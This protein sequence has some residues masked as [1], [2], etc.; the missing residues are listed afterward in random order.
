MN[1]TEIHTQERH[2]T[3]IYVIF[4]QIF[5]S[6]LWSY[7]IAKGG[8]VCLSCTSPSLCPY[9]VFVTSSCQLGQRFRPLQILFHVMRLS[10]VQIM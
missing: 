9:L 7:S 3:A 8:R 5:R 10:L 2:V 6:I 1:V 4:L